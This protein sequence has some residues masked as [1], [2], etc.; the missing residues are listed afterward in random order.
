MLN[1]YRVSIWDDESFDVTEENGRLSAEVVSFKC[2][3]PVDLFWDGRT[4]ANDF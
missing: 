4:T 1:V 2:Q 3:P